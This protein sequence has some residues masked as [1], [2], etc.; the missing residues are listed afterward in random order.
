MLQHLQS[1]RTKLARIL[2]YLEPTSLAVY[3]AV[4][5]PRP[6]FR[7]LD[8]YANDSKK[9]TM[10]SNF[11]AYA[12]KVTKKWLNRS[13]E[14]EFRDKL[15]RSSEE[16]SSSSEDDGSLDPLTAII[17]LELKEFKHRAQHWAEFVESRKITSQ[18]HETKAVFDWWRS[19]AT[20]MPKLKIVAATLFSVQISSA[21]VGVSCYRESLN[22]LGGPV[23]KICCLEKI[24]NSARYESWLFSDCSGS[25]EMAFVSV[26]IRK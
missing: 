11:I 10:K 22:G 1:H 25:S 8:V 15:S 9:D 12:V 3:C 19:N 17:K 18:L 2:K 5:D 7:K 26:L 20:A 16:A 24:Y 14:G 23:K 21:S 4:L 13:A 6:H